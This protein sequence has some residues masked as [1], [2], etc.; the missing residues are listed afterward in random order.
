VDGLEN[1]Q[2]VAS[3]I[4]VYSSENVT[5]AGTSSTGLAFRASVYEP[6]FRD[7]E[8]GRDLEHVYGLHN[9]TLLQQ[10][11]S[12]GLSGQRCLAYP[13]VLQ[14]RR[15]AMCLV[16]ST[17]PGVLKWLAFLLVHP[18][19]RVMST[20]HVMPQRAD[21][22]D[23]T[24]TA[25]PLYAELAQHSP[26]PCMLLRIILEYSLVSGVIEVD[27][28][29]RD[30]AVLLSERKR[31]MQRH[32]RTVFHLRCKE[33]AVDWLDPLIPQKRRSQAL[34]EWKAI[35]GNRQACELKASSDVFKAAIRRRC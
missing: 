19:Q 2:I 14:H 15:E 8:T 20:A 28:A 32:S 9:F 1:E 18:Y 26:L 29:L 22:L 4:Y 27:E 6:S 25:L 16:D 12:V 3:G 34:K 10:R 11:G 33:E 5:T 31:L 13:N 30:R 35:K 23:P 17:R 7:R 21:W 24:S